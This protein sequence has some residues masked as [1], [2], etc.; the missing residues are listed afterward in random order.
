VF[1]GYNCLPLHAAP[2]GGKELMSS[3]STCCNG[4]PGAHR[5]RGRIF[6]SGSTTS[7]LLLLA[8]TPKCPLCLLA[9]AAALGLGAEWR[10]ALLF[11]V[12]PVY[13]WLITAVLLLPLTIHLARRAHAFRQA[14]L[15]SKVRNHE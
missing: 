14:H 5:H 11:A 9:W 13:R 7:A 6:R 3:A 12:D 8:L 10:H 4:A 1:D 2:Q 15:F